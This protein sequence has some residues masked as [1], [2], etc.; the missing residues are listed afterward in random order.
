MKKMIVTDLDG[1][2]LNSQRKCSLETFKYLKSLKEEGYIVVIATGRIL[3][4]ALLVTDGALFANYIICNTGSLIYDV[5][6]KTIIYQKE[7]D[8]QLIEQVYSYYNPSYMS[9]IEICDLNY[10]HK[11][12]HIDY[13]DDELSKKITNID[14]FIEHC[15]NVMSISITLDNSK[16]DATLKLLQPLTGLKLDV[17]QDSFGDDCWIEILAENVSKYSAI[18]V[19]ADLKHVS[20]DTIIAFGDGRND[21]DMVEKCGVGVAM[22]NALADLKNIADYVTLTNDQEGIMHFLKQYL[23]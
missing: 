7:I 15:K 11:L 1:T 4:S 2:F 3:A 8:K 20:N 17:M 14:E 9:R 22:G 23:K 13:K 19:L 10:Y 6:N 16:I 21:L 12:T 18:K 5:E